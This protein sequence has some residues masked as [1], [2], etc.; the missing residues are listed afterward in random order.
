M[1][2]EDREQGRTGKRKKKRG[3]IDWE[4]IRGKEVKREKENN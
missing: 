2:R 1:R 3:C 4:E